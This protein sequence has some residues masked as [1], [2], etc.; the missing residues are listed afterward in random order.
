MWKGGQ[1]KT[2]YYCTDLHHAD[3]IL[4][5][6]QDFNCNDKQEHLIDADNLITVS[7]DDKQWYQLLLR[8]ETSLPYKNMMMIIINENLEEKFVVE[9]DQGKIK[10]MFFSKEQL[11]NKLSYINLYNRYDMDISE[12]VCLFLEQLNTPKEVKERLI[13]S[14]I[15]NDDYELNKLGYRDIIIQKEYEITNSYIENN[16]PQ[17]EKIEEQ[18]LSWILDIENENIEL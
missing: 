17:E 7:L 14:Y 12:K 11:N 15:S 1:M 16:F 10:K 13:E 2:M 9:A 4:D 18:V 3:H 8:N 6:L 5:Y